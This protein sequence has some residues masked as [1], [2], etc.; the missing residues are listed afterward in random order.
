M[1]DVAASGGY[2]IAM[3]ADEVIADPTTIT[4][5]IGVITMFPGFHEAM[6]RLGLRTGGSSGG[7][8]NRS[9]DIRSDPGRGCSGRM[10]RSTLRRV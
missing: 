2:W 9:R 10:R 3:A 4:G 7:G 6:G 5:S 8:C 1:G